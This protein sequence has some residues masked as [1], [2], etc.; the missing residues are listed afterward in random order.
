MLKIGKLQVRMNPG[1][2]SSTKLKG[3]KITDAPKERPN[4]ITLDTP[5]EEKTQMSNSIEK[6]ERI[7]ETIQQVGAM[8]SQTIEEPKAPPFTI[9][10]KPFPNDT[11]LDNENRTFYFS[12]KLNGKQLQIYA[13]PGATHSYLGRNSATLV[14][15]HIKPH[16]ISSRA[17]TGR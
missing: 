3:P 10:S 5:L 1:Q 15:D 6:E 12:I 17:P 7:T 14:K 13:D 11:K 8:E 2:S 4:E 9:T 16:K